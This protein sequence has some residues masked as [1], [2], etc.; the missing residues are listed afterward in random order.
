MERLANAPERIVGVTLTQLVADGHLSLLRHL[1]RRCPEKLLVVGGHPVA[2]IESEIAEKYADAC[3]VIV[4][5]EGDQ[6]IVDVARQMARGTAAFDDVP[7][8]SFGRD[9]RRVRTA[10]RARVGWASRPHAARDAW[11]RRPHVR[12]PAPRWSSSARAAI[13]A[14]P[15]AAWPRSTATGRT[16]GKRAR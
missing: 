12:C 10:L 1:K 4:C 8:I 6:T 14:A 3:D 7:G 11:E 5:G 9:G 15:S 13:S 16:T 2:A